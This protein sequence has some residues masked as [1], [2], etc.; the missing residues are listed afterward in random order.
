MLPAGKILV[1]R[2]PQFDEVA[3]DVLQRRIVAE[4]LRHRAE[5]VHGRLD[6]RDDVVHGLRA[7]RAEHA[8]NP[9]APLVISM[10][11]PSARSL[12]SFPSPVFM[13][14]RSLVPPSNELCLTISTDSFSWSLRFR[15]IRPGCGRRRTRPDQRSRPPA[16]RR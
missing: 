1:D 16:P 10:V 15:V 5:P 4:V 3:L 14:S 6:V 11:E 2:R 12:E 8:R 9:D 13:I 7:L